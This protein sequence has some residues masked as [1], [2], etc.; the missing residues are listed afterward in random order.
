M[1]WGSRQSERRREDGQMLVLFCL[2]L[3][4]MIGLVG[5]VIDGGAAYAQRRSQQNASDLAALAAADA[6]YNG[7]T[8]AEATTVAQAV[9]ASNFAGSGA[10]VTVTFPDSKVQV[11]VSAPHENSFARLLGQ[12]QWQVSTTA[13]AIAGVRDTA[14]GAAP[15]IMPIQDFNADGTPKAAYTEG[16]CAPAGCLWVNCQP[17]D[18]PDAA[19]GWAWTVYGNP[20]NANTSDIAAY[21]DAFGSCGGTAVADVTVTAGEHPDWG[22]SNQGNHNGAIS[23]S[24]SC[25]VGLDVPVPIVGPPV[26]PATT[27]S[28]TT[29]TDGCFMGW[30]I[31]HVSGIAKSGADSHWLGWF[32][33]DEIEYPNLLIHSSCTISTCPA[34]GQ[35]DLRLVN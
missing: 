32:L 6:L 18:A 34:F 15:V 2:A 20:P 10:S 25:I 12:A 27:C 26:A 21:L 17:C 24:G 33:P 11:D 4:A 3:V 22:Q 13:Q 19:D 9:A 16:N 28:N 31:F 1:D 29:D 23:Q 14:T 30:A 35:A 8:Q 7:R 5:L